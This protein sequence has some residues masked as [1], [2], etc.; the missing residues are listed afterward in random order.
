MEALAI[1]AHVAEVHEED[2]VLPAEVADDLAHVLA[3]GAVAALAQRHAQHVA[4]HQM[5]RPV[6]RVLADQ[7]ALH[8]AQRGN[9]RVVRMQRQAHAAFLGHRHDFAQEALEILPQLRLRDSEV[10]LRRKVL[11]VE[12]R[13]L[14]AAA[15]GIAAG[16]AVPADVRHEVHAQRADAQPA[17]VAHDRLR[18]V[19]GLVRARRAALDVLVDA[20]GQ[21]LHHRRGQAVAQE[22]IVEGAKVRLAGQVKLSILGQANHRVIHTQLLVPAAHQVVRLGQVISQKHV[23]SSFVRLQPSRLLRS[24]SQ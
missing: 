18:L 11:H 10:V 6:D 4:L 2:L 20:A 24:P 16:R 8:P 1:A 7:D 9:R 12:G 15:L 3:H 13:T 22:M 23:V 19:H 14:R 21:R 17:H 5:N